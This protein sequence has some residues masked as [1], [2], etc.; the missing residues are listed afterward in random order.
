MSLNFI[1]HLDI[2]SDLQEILQTCKLAPWGCNHQNSNWETVGQM[3]QLLQQVNCKEIER[4]REKE[5]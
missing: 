3:I 1:N 4:E 5:G 2:T